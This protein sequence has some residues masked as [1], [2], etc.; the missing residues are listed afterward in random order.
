MLTSLAKAHLVEHT[1]TLVDIL[2]VMNF[3]T[4]FVTKVHFD[5]QYWKHDN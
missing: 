3:S 4:S 2:Y 1:V 5:R